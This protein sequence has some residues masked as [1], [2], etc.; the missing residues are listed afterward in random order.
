MKYLVEVQIV[1]TIYV[2]VEARNELDA[3]DAVDLCNLD[4]EIHYDDPEVIRVIPK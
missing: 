1:Q 4:G 3:E 2:E